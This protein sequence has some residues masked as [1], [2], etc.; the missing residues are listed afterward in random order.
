V[1]GKCKL[2]QIKRRKIAFISFYFL[3]RIGAFQWVTA[4]SNKKFPSSISGLAKRLN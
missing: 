3:C 4:D 2:I 1:Q